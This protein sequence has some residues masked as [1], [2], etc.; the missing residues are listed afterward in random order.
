MF[1]FKSLIN[2]NLRLK[3]STSFDVSNSNSDLRLKRRTQIEHSNFDI[4]DYDD[5]ISLQ[6]ND[7]HTSTISMKAQNDKSKNS[8]ENK[9]IELFEINSLRKFSTSSTSMNRSDNII[10][11]QLFIVYRATKSLTNQFRKYLNLIQIVIDY[12]KIQRTQKTSQLMKMLKTSHV[13]PYETIKVLRKNLR[14][15]SMLSRALVHKSKILFLSQDDCESN[16]H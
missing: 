6:I 16:N 11:R 1:E 14:N 3:K 12:V 15:E 2:L 9:N 7:E 10:V 5:L 4:K 13:E 8:K